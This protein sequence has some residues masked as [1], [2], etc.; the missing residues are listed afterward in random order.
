MPLEDSLTADLRAH[1]SSLEGIDEVKMFG[2]LA[3]MLNGNM[4][5]AASKRGLLLRVGKDRQQD[6]LARPGARPMEMNGRIMYGYIYVDPS[7]LSQDALHAWL[8]DAARFVLTLPPKS[9]SKK[10]TKRGRGK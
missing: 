4:L 2:G 1:L 3:F 10:S 8:D 5:A 9:R 6:A 7:A